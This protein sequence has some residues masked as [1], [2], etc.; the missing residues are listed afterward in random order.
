MTRIL[1][2]NGHT[3]ECNQHT[4]NYE[5]ALE[6]YRLLWPNY[7]TVCN[8]VGG[9]H[10][11]YDPSPA[12]VSLSPGSYPDFDPC[13]ACILRGICPRCGEQH[14]IDQDSDTCEC[15]NCRWKDDDWSC[16]APQ[17]WDW[18]SCWELTPEEEE[19][20]AQELEAAR[21]TWAEDQETIDSVLNYVDFE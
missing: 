4:I 16:V 15:L 8:A 1:E 5:T 11:S 9:F 3:A 6:A 10:S 13:S 20:L 21:A 12:G 14:T 2:P 17:Q 7:C 19:T 18:C